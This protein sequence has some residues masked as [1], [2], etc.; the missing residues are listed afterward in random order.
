MRRFLNMLRTIYADGFC[1]WASDR[2][3]WAYEEPDGR[4]FDMHL[5][6]GDLWASLEEAIRPMGILEE[7][8]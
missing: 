2:Y 8:R 1:R 6:V 3:A 7:D 5:A 4:Y